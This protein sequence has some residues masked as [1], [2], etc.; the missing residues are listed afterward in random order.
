MPVLEAV[1]TFAGITNE[2]EF[3]SHHYLAEVFKGDIKA[4]LEAWDAQEAQH[5]GDD[6]HRAPQKRLQAWAQRWFALRGQVQRGKDEHERWQAFMQI[7][8]GLLQALGYA[9]PPSTLTLHELASGLPLPVWHLQGQRL[10]IIPAYQASREDD[11][12]LDHQL[13]AFHYGTE[14]LPPQVKGETWADLLSDAVFGAD[15]PPRYVLLLGLDEWLL[16]DRYKWP[17]NRALR[18]DWADILDR[19]DADTLK[20]CAALLHQDSL[21]PGEGNSLLESLDENAHKHAFGVSEDLKYALREAI[22][23]LGNEAARQLDEQA[24]GSKKS[25]YSGQYKLDASVLSLECLR[26]VYRLL[27]MFYIEA[28][29]ELGYVPINK[30]EVYLKGYS[31][32]SLRDLELQPLPTQQAREGKYFDLTLR[33]LFK[34]VAHGCGMGGEQASLRNADQVALQGAKDTFA[35]APLD[36][37][38]FDD[39]SMPLLGKVQFPNAVWQ[40]VIKLLSLSKGQGRGRRS[41]RVSYQLLSINQLGAVYEAL[42]SY[43]GFFADEDLYEV[44]PAPK[45]ASASASDGGDV[46]G[47]EDD[48]EDGDNAPSR[49]ARASDSDADMLENAWFVPRSRIDDYKDDEKVYDVED[50]RRKL[51]MHPKGSF[52]YR[53]AGRDRQKSASYYTPQVLTQCLVKYALKELLDEKNGRIKKADDILTLTVCEPAMGSAAFLNEAVNQLAEAYLERKQAELKTRIPHDQYPQELQKVRMYL[54]DRN[55]FGVDL[56]PVA[57][58]LAEV[59]IWLNAIYGEQDDNGQPLPARVPWFGYQLFAGN[60]LIGARHQVYNAAALKKGAKPAWHEAPPRRATSAAP[61]RADEIWHFLLPDPGMGDYTDKVAKSLY[62]DDFARLK[63][64]RKALTA[65]L[66]DYEVA[67]LQQLSQ[68]VEALWAQH[69]AALARDRARTEDMLRVWPHELHAKSASGADT[70]SASSYESSSDGRVSRAQKETIRQQGLLNEDGDLATPFRRLK[71]VMDYWCALW[72]WPITRSADLPSREQWWMEIGAI[73][74]GNVV[75]METQRGLELQPTAPEAPQVIVPEVQPAFE[76]FETQLPLTQAS[77][78]PTGGANPPNLHDKFGHLRI[79]RLRQH[80]ARVAVVE[81]IAE[82]RRFMHWEL[83]FA[84]VLLGARSGADGRPSGGFDLILGN[85]PWLKVE[86]NEAG[87]LGERNPVFA[88]RKISASDL[89]QLRAEAFAQF[90]GLQSDWTDELQEAEG[91]QNFLNAVQ[92]YPLLKGMPA[93]LYKCFMPLAWSLNSAQGVTGLLHPEGPYDDPKGGNL[94]EAVYARLRSHF[95]FTNVKLL[96]QEVMIWVRYSINIYGCPNARPTFDNISNV[97]VPAT[98]DACYLHDGSGL[99][100]GIKNDSGQWNVAGHSDRI[101]RIDD[102]A[103]ATFAQLYDEPGTTACRARLPALHAGA[104]N[105]VLAKLAAYPRRLADLGNGYFSTEMWNETAQQKDGTLSRRPNSESGFV[106]TPHDWVLSGPHF[107]V[108]NPFY[109]TPRKNCNTPRA[110]DNLDLQTLPDDYLPRTNYRPMPDRA[111]YLRRTPRVSWLVPG[112]MQGRPVT[113]FFRYVNRRRLSQS[114]ERTLISALTPPLAAHVHPVLSL[115][116]RSS[117]HLLDVVGFTASVAADFFIKS[118]GQGDLYDSTLGRLPHVSSSAVSARV[119]ALNCLTTHYAPLWEQVYD[120]DFADQCWS[121]PG[122]PRLPH[123]FWPALTSTWTRDC[124]LRADYARRMALVEID[125]LVAHALGLTLAELL[126][127]YRVQFPVLQQN[128]RDTWYDATGRIIFTCNIGLAAGVGMERKGSRTTPRTLITTPDGKVR[129]GNFGWD[130][131]WTYVS[132]DAGDS[133]EAQKRGG[134]PKYPDG[135][136]ITQ[137]LMDDTLP[138]GPRE[139]PRTYTAPF[140]RASREEDYRVA[141]EFFTKDKN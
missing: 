97:F 32:E 82:Q 38:L 84:D 61:R 44:K 58:E 79:S 4:R 130:D 14:P 102:T 115:T 10:A 50:G 136:T 66:G 118:T 48:A 89:A 91:T 111:E 117:S 81:A 33:R 42:L 113:E 105:S 56:N 98:V 135:T 75:E 37:R 99:P 129:E 47:D 52:I 87:I 36:S 12:L 90:P 131:L 70:T 23:L 106:A 31:L 59:S 83:C 110:Y 133:E 74:E 121:Q 78:Q 3:Y 93:N 62:P 63:A 71:L 41:G 114:G 140:A 127:I 7:Q 60:S 123:S 65:P 35:L 26:M 124:A 95:Q 57:V 64:W 46:E 68:Q 24:S 86:W 27:F 77:G 9:P 69:T 28:R 103:L 126:L 13:T 49:P 19:K 34:L 73:L 11:D 96:F 120:L 85:P 20:A 16:L 51:R 22:E 25:V 29:P 30:S 112:E 17:N 122:N 2:N 55:V 6:A 94:R 72:F 101:V 43:R 54:A 18:F 8:A 15:Q 40:R 134:T 21:A 92:N 67:R 139:V 128:E 125:V 119:L 138:G 76:G 104:L 88:V 53:L 45:K 137:W 80:F 108:G 141:W 100:D 1:Q 107:F 132:A 5:P 116:F 39:A 109:K